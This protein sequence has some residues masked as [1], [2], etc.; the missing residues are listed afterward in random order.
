MSVS[1]RVT[2]A[3]DPSNPVVNQYMLTLEK[4]LLMNMTSVTTVHDSY[5]HT[6][7]LYARF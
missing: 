3:G 7:P 4:L 6:I 2:V 1:K 5:L